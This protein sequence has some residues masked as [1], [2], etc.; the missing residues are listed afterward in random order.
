M[1]V[2]VLSHEGSRT[3]KLNALHESLV[4]AHVHHPNVVR[5]NLLN[6]LPCISSALTPEPLIRLGERSLLQE[7]Q[8]LSGRLCIMLH[9]PSWLRESWLRPVFWKYTPLH[10]VYF[11]TCSCSHAG[12]MFRGQ[13]AGFWD[14]SYRHLKFMLTHVQ[15]AQVM[16]YQIHTV[17]H[18]EAPEA[19]NANEPQ[20]EAEVALRSFRIRTLSE[21]PRASLEVSPPAYNALTSPCQPR[22]PT[23]LNTRSLQTPL[24]A[25][26]FSAPAAARLLPGLCLLSCT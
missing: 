14:N 20:D 16:T 18:I 2:K 5:I 26:S 4:A 21:S 25:C 7:A 23:I 8:R 1:A 19:E 11:P 6:Y 12:L 9:P 15:P 24:F 13:I 10:Y 22:Q 17:Q 3:A